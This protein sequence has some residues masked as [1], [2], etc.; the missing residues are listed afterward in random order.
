MSPWE[1]LA[2]WWLEEVAD[3]AYRELIDPLLVELLAEHQPGGVV[4]DLG[5]GDGRLLGRVEEMTGAQVVGIE[6]VEALARQSG[7]PVIVSRLPAIPFADESLGGAYAVLVLEH[8]ED[9]V[10][11]FAE[12][13]RVVR[14]GGSLIVISNHPIWTAPSS[15]PISDNDG[16]VLWRPGSYFDRG[17]SIEPAGTGEVIFFHRSMSDLLNAAAD[18]G[19]ALQRVIEQPPGQHELI[20]D[21]PRLIAARWLRSTKR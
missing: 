1:Q 14:P 21:I 19:W 2:D 4:A 9:H 12:T 11:F 17:V 8:I 13:A 5:S 3:P 20:A 10:G 15:T 18:E 7:R 6:L 16:E